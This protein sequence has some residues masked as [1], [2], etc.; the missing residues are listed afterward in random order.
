MDV[1]DS[2]VWVYGMT[3]SCD[4][5]VQLLESVVID[6]RREVAVDAYIFNE[7]FE[8]IARSGTEAA[9]IAELQ[10]RFGEI[11]HGNQQI[12]GPDQEAVSALDV[13][14][15]RASP[16]AQMA[17]Q[18]FD[19]QAKDVPIVWLAYEYRESEPTIYT[20]DRDLSRFT[21]AEHGFEKLGMEYVECRG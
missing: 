10:T 16:K 21:P 19:I 18:G 7:V 20:S 3:Q 1:F 8:G 12:R 6:G 5:A 9:A 4:D 11:I 17:A 2:S 13:D 15:V 14:A